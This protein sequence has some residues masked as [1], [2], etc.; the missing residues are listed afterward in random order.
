MTIILTV[1]VKDM[2]HKMTQNTENGKKVWEY[3]HESYVKIKGINKDM[4]PTF[5]YFLTISFSINASCLFAESNSEKNQYQP[6][7]IYTQYSWL[8]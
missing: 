3:K 6:P 7:C 1:Y 4:N 5:Y 8:S 2:L